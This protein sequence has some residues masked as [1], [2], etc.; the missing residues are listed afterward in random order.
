M[1]TF[2][3]FIEDDRYEVPTL[4]FVVVRDAERARE[5]AAERLFASPHHLGIDIRQAGLPVFRMSRSAQRRGG[6]ASAPAI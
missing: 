6:K 3:F 1:H 4:E 2:E 5:L